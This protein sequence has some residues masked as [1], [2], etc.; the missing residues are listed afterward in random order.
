MLKRQIDHPT[1]ES[2]DMVGQVCDQDDIFDC[3]EKDS[4]K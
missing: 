1:A 4:S 3:L 2:L